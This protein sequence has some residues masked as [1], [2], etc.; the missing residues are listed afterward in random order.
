MAKEKHLIDESG[1]VFCEVRR[2]DVDI[3][4]CLACRRLES[5]DLDSRRPH[6][7]C[8]GVEAEPNLIRI[9]EGA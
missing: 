2:K 5:F 8:R 1:R 4:V 6:L 9:A 3:E 7:V